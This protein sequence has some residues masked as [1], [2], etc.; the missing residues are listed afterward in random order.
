MLTRRDRQK[1][2]E[3]RCDNAGRESNINLILIVICYSKRAAA[4]STS[5]GMSDRNFTH[6]RGHISTAAALINDAVQLSHYKYCIIDYA[7]PQPER[8]INCP[9]SEN[10]LIS[11]SK[12]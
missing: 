3:P 6:S 5:S 8:V 1:T 7:P 10:T 2:V 11:I 12:Y 4:D 9:T